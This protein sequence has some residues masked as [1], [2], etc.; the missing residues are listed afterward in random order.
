MLLIC[1]VYGD[2]HVFPIDIGSE[3]IIGSLKKAIVVENPNRFRGV[4]AYS[5][6]IWKKFIREDDKD[7][8]GLSDL[9]DELRVTWTI[10]EYFNE[11]PPKKMIH[12]VI[13]APKPIDVKS[14]LHN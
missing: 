8:L 11:E 3:Q 4:D 5:L 9:D 12:I 14:K 10:A 6:A 2:S 1:W 13:Q 7:K